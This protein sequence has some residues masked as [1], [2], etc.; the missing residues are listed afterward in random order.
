MSRPFLPVERTLRYTGEQQKALTTAQD[1]KVHGCCPCCGLKK[2]PSF[3]SFKFHSFIHR[4]HS[5]I[6]AYSKC[7]K[8]EQGCIRIFDSYLHLLSRRTR[9]SL[10]CSPIH[11]PCKTRPGFSRSCSKSNHPTVSIAC[12][13]F[14]DFPNVPCADCFQAHEEIVT[15]DKLNLASAFVKVCADSAWFNDCGRLW[16]L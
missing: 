5:I 10:N 14:V 6:G 8:D 11:F 12:F 16:R 15:F 2:V 7:S 9:A 1:V 3:F 13:C 4:V